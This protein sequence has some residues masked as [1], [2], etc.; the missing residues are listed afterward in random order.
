MK[1]IN[2]IGYY[3][4]EKNKEE[5][6]NYILSATNKMD[7]ICLA[8]NALGYTVKILSVSETK[9]KKN[10]KGKCLQL[11]EKKFLKLFPTIARKSKLHVVCQKLL[12]NI[13]LIFYIMKKIKKDESI[14]IYHSLGYYKIISVLKKLKKFRLILEVEEIYSDV[15][16]DKKVKAKEL[17]FFKLA[18]AYIFPTELLDEYINV[19]NKPSVIVYGTYKIEKDRTFK[20]HEKDKKIHLVYAGTFDP[21]KGGVSNAISIGAYLNDN[22]CIHII[23]FGSRTEIEN[24]KYLIEKNNKIGGASITMDGLLNGESYIRFIQGCDIGLCTQ[25]PKSSFNDTSFPSKVLSYL[26]NGLRVVSIKIRVLEKS[27]ISDLLYFYHEN[28]PKEIAEVIKT[29]NFDD[30]YDGRETISNLHKDFVE[31]LEKLLK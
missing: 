24:V 23:G 3:D 18:D 13:C 26:S 14:I 12:I 29:I 10:Y 7:Y 4:C 31:K 11:D 9:N 30:N 19:D 27:K 6:R 5:N 22:Y 2:Y 8:L 21:R 28:N 25:N 17:N 15:T 16:E 1:H 20:F